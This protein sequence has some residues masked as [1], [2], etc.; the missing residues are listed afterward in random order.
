M[1]SPPNR[2]HPAA[3]GKRNLLERLLVECVQSTRA[4]P[5]ESGVRFHVHVPAAANNNVCLVFHVDLP[6]DPLVRE[7]PRPDYLVAHATRD[8][9]ILTIVEMKGK[10][11]QD[12]THG[13]DQIAAFA[14]LLRGQLKEHAPAKLKYV[15]QG[16]LL[17]A[18]GAH[19]PLRK[20]AEMS[21]QGLVIAP[22]SYHHSAE[23][24]P[25]ISTRL[26]LERCTYHHAAIREPRPFS[27]IE[28][29]LAEG[30]LPARVHDP[31]LH[32]RWGP[33]RPG[34]YVNYAHTPA[35]RR[36]RVPA[37]LAALAVDRTRADIAVCTV[38]AATNELYDLLQHALEQGLGLPRER[39]FLRLLRP[40]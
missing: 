36:R 25:Y 4:V 17:M 38:N 6:R 24:Y 21:R 32:E 16:V 1:A 30:V 26:Q 27:P 39:P 22:I 10:G 19:P 7:G 15:I 13:V 35:G 11:E 2:S 40:R 23:L 5:G 3:T 31:F 28:T 37:A 8:A 9:L 33:D 20:L 12:L 34:V 18:H 29:L 14:R